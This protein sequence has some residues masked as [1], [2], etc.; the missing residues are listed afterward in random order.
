MVIVVSE[1]V[2]RDCHDMVERLAF[3]R[4]LRQH[5]GVPMLTRC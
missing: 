3:R 5:C 2:A 4:A 1:Q